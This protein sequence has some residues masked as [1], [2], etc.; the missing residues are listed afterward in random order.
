MT[1]KPQPQAY[2]HELVIAGRAPATADFAEQT[3][4]M[5]QIEPEV[6]ALRDKLIKFGG[7]LTVRPVKNKAADAPASGQTG[8]GAQV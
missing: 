5:G 3:A 2:I 4:L 7:G 8:G 1:T 6:T